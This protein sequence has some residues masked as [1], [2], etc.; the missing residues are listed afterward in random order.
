LEFFLT[1]PGGF[2]ITLEGIDGCG[3]TT[4][5]RLLVEHL[6]GKGLDVLHT[7]EPG[8]TD[9]G[10]RI[11]A[12]LLDPESR[13]MDP[14]CELLLYSADRAQHVAT[15]IKPALA[16]GKIVVCDRYTDATAAYQAYARGLGQEVVEILS[17]IATSGCTPDLTILMD[18]PAGYALSRAIDRNNDTAST[19]SRFEEESVKFHERVREGYLHIAQIEPGRVKVVNAAGTVGDIS[20][21]ITSEVEMALEL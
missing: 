6:R 5:A 17:R 12:I 1:I 4:Q 18:L 3:K 11:R 8:G 21:R 13:G 9:I 2:F 20:V 14:M 10:A 16:E 7:R 15:V 19:E